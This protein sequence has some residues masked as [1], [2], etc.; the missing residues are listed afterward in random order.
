MYAIE[1]DNRRLKRSYGGPHLGEPRWE[2]WMG[3]FVRRGFR[4]YDRTHE[5]DPGSKSLNGSLDPF[6]LTTLAVDPSG[7]GSL[8][9][10]CGR[11]QVPHPPAGEKIV[12]WLILPVVI[13][14]S[15]RLSHACL[16]I[17]NYTVK[18]RMAH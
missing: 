5:G 2:N 17:S 4:F 7:R 11:T 18:L 6:R 12:T 9:L 16:S 14:L 8:G 10:G 3:F 15:Q 13:C 1:R